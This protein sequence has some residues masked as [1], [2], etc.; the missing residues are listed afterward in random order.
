[1]AM[2]SEKHKIKAAQAGKAVKLLS[3]AVSL[4]EAC[5]A[6]NA[7]DECRKALSSAELFATKHKD[8]GSA[9]TSRKRV[10][11]SMS[12]VAESLIRDDGTLRYVSYMR[13]AGKRPD[14]VAVSFR[15]PGLPSLTTSFTLEG[16]EFYEVYKAAVFA[17]AKHLGVS[18][19]CLVASMLATRN[20]FKDRYM[21]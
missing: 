1:M 7:V 3:Q 4:L 21:V 12:T 10:E 18:D 13:R 14:V 20:A 19:K 5:G 15:V 16:R 9:E 8:I 6:V 2:E 17:L 11:R